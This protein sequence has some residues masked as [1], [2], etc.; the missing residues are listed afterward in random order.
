VSVI[1]KNKLRRER[2]LK[3][4]QLLQRAFETQLFLRFFFILHFLCSEDMFQS[5]DYSRPPPVSTAM[6]ASSVAP[7]GASSSL[8]GAVL[9]SGINIPDPGSLMPDPKTAKKE[10][11]EK[12]ISCPTFFVATNIT[13]LKTVLRIRDVYPGS[14]ILIFTH[15]GSRISDPGSKNSNKRER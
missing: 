7:P 6:P 4:A 3:Q 15:S 8:S 1:P 9:R 13:K 5:G 2:G 12:K 14:R 11:D 10:R